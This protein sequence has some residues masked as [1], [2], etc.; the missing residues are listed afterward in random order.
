MKKIRLRNEMEQVIALRLRNEM[1]QECIMPNFFEREHSYLLVWIIR[2]S[3]VGGKDGYVMNDTMYGLKQLV[4]QLQT[5]LSFAPND[6][7]YC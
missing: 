1:E 3:S 2:S 4:L 7:L 5:M 6:A